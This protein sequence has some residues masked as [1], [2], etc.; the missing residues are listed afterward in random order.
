MYV[1]AIEGKK[2]KVNNVHNSL[3]DVIKKTTKNE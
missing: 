1:I 3:T 2:D